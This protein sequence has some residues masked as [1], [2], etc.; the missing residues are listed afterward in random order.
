MSTIR[1]TAA[2]LQSTASFLGNSAQTIADVNQSA[3]AQ[4]ESLVAGGWQGA[5]SNAFANA[6]N[7]WR[8]GAAMVQQ[9]LQTISSLTTSAASAYSETDS[10]VASSFS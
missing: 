10:S 7:E 5:G 4:V 3:M 8:Q 1:V 2:E 6:M 9:A